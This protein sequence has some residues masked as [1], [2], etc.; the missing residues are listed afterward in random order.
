MKKMITAGSGN[1]YDNHLNIYYKKQKFHV[2]IDFY[3]SNADVFRMP[4]FAIQEVHPYD[5]AEYTWAKKDDTNSNRVMYI[6]NGKVVDTSTLWS[7]E[8]DDY[9]NDPD[10]YV[11]DILDNIAAELYDMNQDV[12][13][14]MVHN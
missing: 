12:K 5:D 1:R 3:D 6:R 11:S 14:I 8:P 9:E 7:Y 10:D 2:N 4:R 13:P